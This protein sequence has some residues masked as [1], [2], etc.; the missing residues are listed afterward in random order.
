MVTRLAAFSTSAA[1]ASEG[2]AG[3]VTDGAARTGVGFAPDGAS[4][5]NTSPGMTTVA[6]PPRCNA[7]R[8]AISRMR[9]SCSG[10]LTS[11]Q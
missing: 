5:R 9:G 4:A 1:A 2:S 10:M 7:V 6:T 11:S 3:R 8:I